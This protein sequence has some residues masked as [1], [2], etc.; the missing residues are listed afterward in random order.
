M[1]RKTSRRIRPKAKR[2]RQDKEQ[3][4]AMTRRVQER[5][6]NFEVRPGPT[7]KGKVSALFLAFLDPYLHEVD[8]DT[9]PKLV[10]VGMAAWNA[11]VLPPERENELVE[12]VIRKLS[13]ELH[14]D[15]RR[16]LQ[17]MIRRKK[18]F[19]ADERY[20]IVDY[21]LTDLGDQWHLSVVS[22]PAPEDKE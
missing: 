1:A 14:Q 18:R 2:P 13:A 15:F 19:F 20:F 5:F 6:P 3:V 10:A 22:T 7:E 12:Q 9:Y 4:D 21:E 17:R 8:D 11:A 16:M